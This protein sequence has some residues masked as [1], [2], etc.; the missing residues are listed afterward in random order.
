[1]LRYFYSIKLFIYRLYQRRVQEADT[2]S[3]KNKF[4]KLF[5]TTVNRNCSC[6]STHCSNSSTS[7]SSSTTQ[8][9]TITQMLSQNSKLYYVEQGLAPHTYEDPGLAVQ[10][11]ANEI[12][13]NDIKIE[14]VIG[15][16]LCPSFHFFSSFHTKIYFSLFIR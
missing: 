3:C 6:A 1:M 7:E 9:T 10:Q 5:P 11:F 15:G 14:S 13:P 8:S 16:G 2:K 12:D 4:S